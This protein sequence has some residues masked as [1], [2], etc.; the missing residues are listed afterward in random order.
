MSSNAFKISVLIAIG[1]SVII[2]ACS[3]RTG[4]FVNK[5][6]IAIENI[7]GIARELNAY[8]DKL[9]EYPED[10]TA[11]KERGFFKRFPLNPYRDDPA[12]MM[13][14]KVSTPTAG[15]FSYIKIYRERFSEEIMYY[16]LI[17][18]GPA[19]VENTDVI[20]ASF[21]YEQ[22]HL[23]EWY[24]MPDGKPDRY[25]KIIMGELRLMPAESE[26]VE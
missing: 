14:V 8:F 19:D 18:W 2:L 24:D 3:Q 15:D 20:D 22:A 26:G 1:L 10:I 6:E 5:K 17:L 9:G 11:L 13:E 25:L 7:D 21:D 16:L 4:L 12:E 23:T